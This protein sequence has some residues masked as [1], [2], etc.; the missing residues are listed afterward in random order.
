MYVDYGASD[1]LNEKLI[2]QGY[3]QVSDRTFS[4]SGAF[5]DAETGASQGYSGLWEFFWEDPLD[6][7]TPKR[8]RET[9]AE[10]LRQRSVPLRS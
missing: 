10:K 5:E 2:Q 3:A 4:E 6:R 7:Q 9:V 1:T 8:T